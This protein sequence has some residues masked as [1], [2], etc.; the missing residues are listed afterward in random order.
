MTRF[1]MIFLLLAHRLIHFL[2]FRKI[3]RWQR[4]LAKW[5]AHLCLGCMLATNIPDF[6]VVK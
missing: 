5:A 3:P 4:S 2:D 6:V 1:L